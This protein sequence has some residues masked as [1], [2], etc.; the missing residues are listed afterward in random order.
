INP[1]AAP[2]KVVINSRTGSVVL[3]ERV[4]LRQAAV[5]H[6]NLSIIIDTDV[7]VSQPGAF[8]GGGTVV[9]TE[10]DIRIQQQGGSLH[11]VQGADLR[12]VVDALNALGATPQDLMSILEAL[13]AA[14]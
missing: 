4:T 10:S 7:E 9:T 5:A 11:T 6:G 1:G 12:D 14:G 2:A 8:S 13:K 3:N